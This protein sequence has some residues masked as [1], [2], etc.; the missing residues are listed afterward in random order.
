MYYIGSKSENRDDHEQTYL[1]LSKLGFL[2]NKLQI[3]G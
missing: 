2:Q 3:I 1:I